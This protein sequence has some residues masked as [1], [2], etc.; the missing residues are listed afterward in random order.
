MGEQKL[1][2]DFYYDVAE[3]ESV[4]RTSEDGGLP[5]DL[6]EFYHSFGYDC[7]KRGNLQVLDAEWVMFSGRHCNGGRLMMVM[8]IVMVAVMMMMIIIL[9]MIM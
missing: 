2:D 4:A 8:V 5:Q 9:I 3:Y 1:P 6:V 7:R